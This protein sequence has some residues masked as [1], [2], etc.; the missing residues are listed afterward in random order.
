[1]EPLRDV[2]PDTLAERVRTFVR[3][4]D[5]IGSA[6]FD[7]TRRESAE[8]VISQ[9]LAW[10]WDSIAGPVLEI[11]G[12]TSRNFATTQGWPKVWWSPAGL[13]S[14]LPIHAAGHHGDQ[15]SAGPRT[16]LDCVVSSYTPTVRALAHLRSQLR[17]PRQEPADAHPGRAAHAWSTDSHRDSARGSKPAKERFPGALVLQE[18][19]ASRQ[20]ILDS[21][22]VS[23][24]AHFACHGYSDISDP[25]RSGLILPTGEDEK[26]TV[27]DVSRLHLTGAELA[28]LSACTTALTRPDLADE[29]VHITTAFQLAGYPHVIGTLWPINDS[30][31]VE[32]ARKIY[33]SLVVGAGQPDAERAA[34]AA[35]QCVRSMRDRM[36]DAP[37]LWAAF[38]HAGT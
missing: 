5:D 26:L 37:S 16:A 9:T 28:Y 35:H 31:A 17:A 12:L 32:V 14:F 25:A 23:T 13:M 24:W 20:R 36:P 29:A 38:I 15:A 4:L 1:M 11:L 19:Q 6:R 33:D 8:Q 7:I 22:A 27:L 34:A 2:T 18:E 3:A 30:L 21:L 10:L